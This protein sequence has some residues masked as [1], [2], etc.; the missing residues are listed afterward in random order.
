MPTH[1]EK[2]S[3]QAAAPN[4]KNCYSAKITTKQ[5][6]SFFIVDEYEKN[7]SYTLKYNHNY[8]VSYF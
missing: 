1:A 2:A 4:T 8:V 3:D 7:V 6:F 5:L